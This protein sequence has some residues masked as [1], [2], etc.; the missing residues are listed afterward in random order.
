[1]NDNFQSKLFTPTLILPS[2]TLKKKVPDNNNLATQ[3]E[4]IIFTH[5]NKFTSSYET[6]IHANFHNLET[7]QF[8]VSFTASV[9]FPNNYTHV[10]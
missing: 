3:K 5:E 4:L 1:M 6:K 10:S 9:I 2:P 8:S 7:S